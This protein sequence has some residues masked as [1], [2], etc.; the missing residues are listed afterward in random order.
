MVAVNV[1]RG[2]DFNMVNVKKNSLNDSRW[3]IAWRTEIGQ[4]KVISEFL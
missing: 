2:V 3:H 4:E 1:V